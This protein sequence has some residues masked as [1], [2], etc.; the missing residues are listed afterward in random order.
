ML[1]NVIYI[2]MGVYGMKCMR[3]SKDT[4]DSQVFCP[5]CL[6]VME[7][8]PV[9]PNVTVRLP[10]RSD[11]QFARKPV[12]RKLPTEEE[13]IRSL[14]KRIRVLSWLLA[15]ALAAVIALS[16]PTVYH[17]IEDTATFLPGQNYSSAS[18]AS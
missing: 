17:L 1:Y 10:R 9:N 15:I 16:I 5:E 3:C 4:K 7:Q 14:K 12:R 13:Q 2:K 11:P 6:A 18:D 8:Y